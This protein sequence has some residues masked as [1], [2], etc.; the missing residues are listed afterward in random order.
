M[1]KSAQN[2]STKGELEKALY[3]A[4]EDALKISL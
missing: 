1:Q 4:L 3:V 2:D